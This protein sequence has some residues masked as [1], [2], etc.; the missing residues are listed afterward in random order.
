MCFQQVHDTS[1]DSGVISKTHTASENMKTG[2]ITLTTD[3]GYHEHSSD[4][5]TTASDVLIR[6]TL[7]K[8]EH[9]L[10]IPPQNGDSNGHSSSV[11]SKCSK[12]SFGAENFNTS[13]PHKVKISKKHLREVRPP[14][15]KVSP[16]S[17]VSSDG[18]VPSAL[19][20]NE[21][22]GP[23]N[24][25]YSNGNG[26]SKGKEEV[27]SSNDSNGEKAI[28]AAKALHRSLDND[29]EKPFKV[30]KVKKSAEKPFEDV[31]LAKPSANGIKSKFDKKAQSS[32]DSCRSGGDVIAKPDMKSEP[33]V[34][35]FRSTPKYRVERHTPQKTRTQG[36]DVHATNGIPEK[37]N[38]LQD[39]EDSIEIITAHGKESWNLECRNP[40][41]QL[42]S[43]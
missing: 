26:R 40:R 22:K 11:S 41:F 7:E 35:H 6:S 29:Y 24:G 13:G 10:I 25:S 8:S 23:G 2:G 19:L 5:S 43:L 12:T 1:H 9:S 14:F 17:S 38:L 34:L 33:S 32:T 18:K 27:I 15:D 3:K 42:Y 30:D 37:K 20:S 36:F 28:A 39:L 16:R 21:G 4:E 31:N